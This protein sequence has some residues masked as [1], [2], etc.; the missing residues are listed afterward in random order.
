MWLKAS[1]LSRTNDVAP[2]LHPHT[3]RPRSVTWGG[4]VEWGTEKRYENSHVKLAAGG[5]IFRLLCGHIILWNLLLVTY[6]VFPGLSIAS[7]GDI[8]MPGD[9]SMWDATNSETW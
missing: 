3:F 2:L 1:N 8:E 6:A 5:L 7:D 9:Q 4:W